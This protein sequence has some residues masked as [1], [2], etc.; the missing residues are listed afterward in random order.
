[1]QQ[2]IF[3]GVLCHLAVDFAHILKKVVYYR[4]SYEIQIYFIVWEMAVEV[5]I[6]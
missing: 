5:N 2:V 6:Y 3:Y 1:M 4:L